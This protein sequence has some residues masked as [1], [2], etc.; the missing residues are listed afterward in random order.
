MLA[1]N[2]L[3]GDYVLVAGPSAAAKARTPAI[4]QKLVKEYKEADAR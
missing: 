3:E 4:K 1:M 2:A